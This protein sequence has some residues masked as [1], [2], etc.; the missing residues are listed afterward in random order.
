L[1]PLHPAGQQPSPLAQAVTGWRT[2]RASQSLVAILCQV[3]HAS[4]GGQSAW[5]DAGLVAVS[6]VSQGLSTTPFPQA[7]AQSES[8]PAW[9]PG[10]QQPSPFRSA[11]VGTNTQRAW[12]VSASTRRSS[13]QG[14]PLAQLRGQLPA[15]AVMAVSHA[16]PASRRPFPQLIPQS[17]S[18]SGMQPAGQQPSETR[19][20]AAV[21]CGTHTAEQLA[22]EPCMT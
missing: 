1:F 13:V 6:H 10:G 11:A 14:T 21:G 3:A 16:S 9:A 15:P 7:A 12:Q 20:Q 22:A 18:L 8:I 19:E 17:G 2:Q 5:Q 4:G